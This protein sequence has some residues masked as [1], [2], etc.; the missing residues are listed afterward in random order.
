MGAVFTSQAAVT[1]ST[2]YNSDSDGNAN[3][4]TFASDGSLPS[5]NIGS[6][7]LSVVSSGALYPSSS[8][9][10]TLI[11]LSN[12]G[13]N[14]VMTFT[15]VATSGSGGAQVSS[16]GFDFS[17]YQSGHPSS[18]TW[19]YSSTTLATSVFSGAAQG[20]LS[21]S[22]S[23]ITIAG[24]QS[25]N[26]VGTLNSGTTISPLKFDNF[27]LGVTA[28]PEPVNMALAGFGLVAAGVG[29]GRRLY[30]KSRE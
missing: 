6:A 28:V 25:I 10:S 4:G 23:P 29:I 18:I 13:A 2:F 11:N 24:G 14:A 27:E 22:F 9:S 16:L 17:N 15:L 3:T 12:G 8:S 19:T 20:S 1:W 30:K 5:G 21:Q 7:S 26:I